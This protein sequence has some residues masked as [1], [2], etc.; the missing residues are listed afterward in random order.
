MAVAV[1]FAFLPLFLLVLVLLALLKFLC[2][3]ILPAVHLIQLLLLMS[4]ELI[5]SLRIGP[6]PVHSLTLLILSLL[7]L[8]AIGVLLTL[9][10]VEFSFVFL[11]QPGIGGRIIGMARGGRTIETAT[12]VIVSSAVVGIPV[13]TIGIL[14]VRWTVSIVASAAVLKS[15]TIIDAAA[16]IAP[17]ALDVAT[18]EFAGARGGG[19]F[20]VAVI[21]G[22]PEVTIA[23]GSFKVMVLL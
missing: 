13:A 12:V 1:R 23:T 22:G 6:V 4:L 21:D 10:F 17:T 11:L 16:V 14:R 2:L 9:H 15:A 19:D 8:L 7:Q 20:R 3:L 18:T 5:L